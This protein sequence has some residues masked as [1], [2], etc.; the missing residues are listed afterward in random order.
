M[1]ED[2]ETRW[3][4]CSD[5]AKNRDKYYPRT[6][7]IYSFNDKGEAYTLI[8]TAK[9]FKELTKKDTDVNYSNR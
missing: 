4:K 3:I 6:L 2:L 9:A 8:Y 1:N 5:A 7:G